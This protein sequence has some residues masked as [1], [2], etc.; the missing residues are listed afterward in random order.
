MPTLIRPEYHVFDKQ[1]WIIQNNHVTP[2]ARSSHGDTGE[3]VASQGVSCPGKTT[4]QGQ[5]SG[6]PQNRGRDV[7]PQLWFWGKTAALLQA[8]LLLV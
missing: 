8:T 2:S 7:T 6:I 3:V 4:E 1:S 5:A